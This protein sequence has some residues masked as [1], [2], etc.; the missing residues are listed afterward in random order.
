MVGHEFTQLVIECLAAESQQFGGSC[1][2]AA[3]TGHGFDKEL[4]FNVEHD[5]FEID[6]SAEIRLD[7]NR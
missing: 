3:M 7:A 6:R 1:D 5:R 2:V 4:P